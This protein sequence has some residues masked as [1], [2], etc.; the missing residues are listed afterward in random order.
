[1]TLMVKSKPDHLKSRGSG[2]VYTTVCLGYMYIRMYVNTYVCAAHFY[3]AYTYVFMYM[4]IYV[5][6]LIY[7]D[8]YRYMYI[9]IRIHVH[10]YT[11]TCTNSMYFE[12]PPS[13]YIH[14]HVCV[15][16]LLSM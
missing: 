10:T 4:F 7:T 8:L 6:V 11:H 5:C 13:M 3:Y 15:W 1:M 14:M 16:K 2:P 9:P 12:L